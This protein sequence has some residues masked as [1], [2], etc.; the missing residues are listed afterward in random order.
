METQKPTPD[1]HGD[2]HKGGPHQEFEKHEIEK[3]DVMIESLTQ[4]KD[5]YTEAIEQNL[6]ALQKAG[7]GVTISDRRPR[8][9]G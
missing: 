2:G 3:R 9:P 7:Q 8:R 6:T 4:T 5:K 1:P